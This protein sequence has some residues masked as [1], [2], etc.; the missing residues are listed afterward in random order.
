MSNI[1]SALQ[2]RIPAFDFLGEVYLF[3]SALLTDN[4]DD[5][6]LLLVYEGVAE[7]CIEDKKG[8]IVDLVVSII[9]IECHFV[10]LSRNEIQQSHFL[11]Y[12]TYK[13]I[14]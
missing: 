5:I 11:N 4:P 6:D 10:T 12:I 13:K 3:G 7:Q 8:E 2:E 9:G 1:L 14:K